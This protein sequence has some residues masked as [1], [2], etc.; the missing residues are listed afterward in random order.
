MDDSGL[1]DS[2]DG[3]FPWPDVD[4]AR[5]RRRLQ[6]KHEVAAAKDHYRT[7][8]QA[9]PKCGKAAKDLDWFYSESP[10]WTWQNLCGRAGWMSVCDDCHLQVDFFLEI[11]N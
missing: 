2:Q 9:C 8:A 11:L 6:E 5:N 4:A 7:Q 3:Q 1:I 10:A